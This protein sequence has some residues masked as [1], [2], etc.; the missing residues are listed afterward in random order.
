MGK[1]NVYQEWN[2]KNING[3]TEVNNNYLS[4]EAANSDTAEMGYVVGVDTF[5]ADDLQQGVEY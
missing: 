1:K 3:Q 2:G 5:S 4:K